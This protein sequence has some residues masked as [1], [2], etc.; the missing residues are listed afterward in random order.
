MIPGNHD[1]RQ[2]L[3][4]AFLSERYFPDDGYLYYAIDDYPLRLIALDT[5]VT[6]KHQARWTTSNL[7]GFMQRLP[8]SPIGR[9]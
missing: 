1:T 2:S 9:R 8:H 7:L 3:R 5:L 6:G 4:E